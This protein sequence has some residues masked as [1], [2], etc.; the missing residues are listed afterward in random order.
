MIEIIVI[1]GVQ[2][3]LWVVGY[4]IYQKDVKEQKANPEPFFVSKT[5]QS[6]FSR[7]FFNIGVAFAKNE[8]E[9]EDIRMINRFCFFLV[10]IYLDNFFY[11]I[12]TGHYASAL[13]FVL[14]I[15]NINIT[16][17]FILRFNKKVLTFFFVFTCLQIF[18]N[19]KNGSSDWLTNLYYIPTV[20]A[21]FFIFDAKKDKKYILIIIITVI[22]GSIL[23]MILNYYGIQR[24][25]K[26]DN[27]TYGRFKDITNVT[28]LIILCIYFIH[29]KQQKILALYESKN[30]K[31]QEISRLE[32]KVNSAFEEVVELA[33][34]NAP[35]FLTR[36]QEVYPKFS[37]ELLKIQPN[38]TQNDLRTLAYM[39]LNFSTKDIAIYTFSTVDAIKKRKSRIRKSL[40]IDDINTL[41]SILS[42]L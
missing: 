24:N 11:E 20:M 36:F 21:L 38:L 6:R 13:I 18:F 19:A 16:G 34:T 39:K 10:F 40:N 23:A 30:K 26:N 12:Y 37:E 2:F 1:I 7:L 8:I 29:K 27:I 41:Y 28:V 14:L 17:F 35:E 15:V 5:H 3:I 32:S 42:T 4:F 25:V 22:L 9:V 31:D 33:K